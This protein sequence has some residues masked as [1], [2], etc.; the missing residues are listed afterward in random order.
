MERISI[1]NVVRT[2]N[3][4]DGC[5]CG[6]LGNYSLKSADD[7]EAANK[8]SGWAANSLEDVRPR[9]VAIAVRK[10]NDAIDEFGALA[11]PT[12]TGALEYSKGDVWFCRT[13]T[14]V[15]ISRNGRNTTAYFEF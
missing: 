15:S 6:C 5:A 13:E 8:G 14:F 1:E 11:T 4:K 9:A 12:S 2:Y 10:C 7:I 3:G